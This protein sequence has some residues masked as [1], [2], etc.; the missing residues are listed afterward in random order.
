MDYLKIK[1]LGVAMRKKLNK[2][3]FNCTTFFFS[4]VNF[5]M[6]IKDDSLWEGKKTTTQ[7]D[8]RNPFYLWRCIIVI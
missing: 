3:V 2:N 4:K 1:I 5:K 7:S 6:Q 8:I